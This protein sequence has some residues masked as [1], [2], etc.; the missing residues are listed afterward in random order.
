ML[1]PLVRSGET[2]AWADTDIPPG[3]RWA[4]E[5]DQ[6]LASARIG[7]LFV[8]ADFLASDFIM[9]TEVP[10]LEAAAAAGELT[11]I[12][13]AAR[14]CL[15]EASPLS[16]Y[17]AANNPDKPLASLSKN[18]RQEQLAEICRKIH[19]VITASSTISES[20]TTPTTPPSNP[21]VASLWGAAERLALFGT[22]KA[23]PPALFDELVWVLNPPPGIIAGPQAPQGARVKDLLDWS[24]GVGKCSLDFIN[25]IMRTISSH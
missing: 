9:E 3:A 11:L 6:A 17:Q 19:S 7:V 4:D 25:D 5:I 24:E 13:I 2:S 23:L 16:K 18:A 8:S 20:K 14:H 21:D 1:D 22:L 10:A 12:W 15:Y